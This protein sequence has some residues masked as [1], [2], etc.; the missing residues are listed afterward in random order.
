[1]SHTPPRRFS[2]RDLAAY[3]VAFMPWRRELFRRSVRLIAL[4]RRFRFVRAVHVATTA[5]TIL[6]TA[7]IM[8]PLTPLKSHLPFEP[9]ALLSLIWAL[10][11]NDWHQRVRI[12]RRLAWRWPASLQKLDTELGRELRS[13]FGHIPITRRGEASWALIVRHGVK[14]WT[15]WNGTALFLVTDPMT[16]WVGIPLVTTF[17]LV[18]VTAVFKDWLGSGFSPV[19]AI[20]MFPLM[21]ATGIV[22]LIRL[23]RARAVVM[24]LSN[25]ICLSCGYD[26]RGLPPRDGDAMLVRCPEC[27]TAQFPTNNEPKSRA[28]RSAR[29]T[30]MS[31][32]RK[33]D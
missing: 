20:L 27:G 3:L 4:S 16:S 19:L 26:L 9:V 21:L 30:P 5:I 8:V 1:M 14:D 22:G 10:Q 25:G 29:S 2:R 7:A 32:E 17:V 18:P 11:I 12:M 15:S 31:T 6:G 13:T 28:I 33:T 23:R 24:E